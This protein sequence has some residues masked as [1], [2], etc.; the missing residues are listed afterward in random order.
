MDLEEHPC[1]EVSRLGSAV[2]R[3]HGK[4]DQV[5]RTPLNRRVDGVAPV[6]VAKSD[7]PRREVGEGPAPAEEG[8]C[9][10]ALGRLLD[11][12]VHR[13][14]GLGEGG[15]EPLDVCPGLLLGDPQFAGEAV[16]ADPVEDPEVDPLG[17]VAQLRSHRVLGKAEDPGGRHPVEVLPGAEGLDQRLVLGEVSEDAKL[18]LRVVRPD[19]APTVRGDEG[20][21][22]PLPHL[23]ADRDVLQIGIGRGE[24]ARRGRGLV[25]GRMNPAG[26]RVDRLGKALDVRVQ[27]L[28]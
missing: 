12:E 10:A 26:R 14:L 28:L 15:E 19:Q 24:A 5:S 25:E 22:D 8:L 21:A 20:T 23:G 16:R 6:K 13:L 3:E 18:D 1:L 2:D 9:V 7:V 27:E 11:H 17:G 4:L